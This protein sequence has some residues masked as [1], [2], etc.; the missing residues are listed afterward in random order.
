MPEPAPPAETSL[1]KGYH[2]PPG[3]PPQAPQSEGNRMEELPIPSKIRG[4]C[5]P[6]LKKSRAIKRVTG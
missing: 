5:Y 6:D 3:P 1:G 2:R 4:A